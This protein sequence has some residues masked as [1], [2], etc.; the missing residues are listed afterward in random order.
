M[1]KAKK[2]RLG[3]AQKTIGDYCLLAASP[4]DANAHYTT[5]IELAR[6]TGDVFWHAGAL[7]GSACALLVGFFPKALSYHVECTLT[8]FWVFFAMI[9]CVTHDSLNLYHK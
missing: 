7:E 6:L 2:K 8:I 5:G 4:L 9:K 3:R 1:I